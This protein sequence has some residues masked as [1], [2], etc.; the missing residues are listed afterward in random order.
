MPT[1]TLINNYILLLFSIFSIFLVL[2][3][4]Q[5][6]PI[7]VQIQSLQ[8][9]NVRKVL[10]LI[11]HPDDE[12]MFFSPTILNL[13]PHFSVQVLCLSTGNDQ[14]VGKIRE[15]E[16][17]KSC[18][19]LGNVSCHAMN[20]PL[21]Q[22]GMSNQWDPIVIYDIVRNRIKSEKIDMVQSL[23]SLIAFRL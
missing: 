19:T 2:I 1:A 11:A 17:I 7:S 4:Y 22:D 14:G 9:L 20:H 15:K 6:K 10:L 5:S 21:I 8:S 3:W 16:L 12:C 13:I 23:S 18:K